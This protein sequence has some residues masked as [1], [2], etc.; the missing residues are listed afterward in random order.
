MDLL[1]GNVYWLVDHTPVHAR[2][3]ERYHH[4]FMTFRCEWL[5]GLDLFW[6]WNTPMCLG[7]WDADKYVPQWKQKPL[8]LREYWRVHSLVQHLIADAF[9]SLTE[10]IA[11]QSLRYT[12]FRS[13]FELMDKKADAQIQIS[14]LAATQGLTPN[15]FARVFREHFHVSPK[16][17]LNRRLNVSACQLLLTTDLTVSQVARRLNFSDAFYFNRF[18]RKMNGTSPARYRKTFRHEHDTSS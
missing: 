2:C 3:T 5:P 16:E 6:D 4:Y 13:V 11:R 9:P 1:P 7:K 15:S 17:Y 14:E 10:T 18:F 12:K 8:P